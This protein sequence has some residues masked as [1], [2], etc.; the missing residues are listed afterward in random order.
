MLMLN[1]AMIICLGFL[2]IQY[3]LDKRT[4]LIILTMLALVLWTLYNE[5]AMMGLV[6]LCM[7]MP[8]LYLVQLPREYQ[9][10][11]L[12]YVTKWFAV[13]LIPSLIIYWI[14]LIF[15]IPSFGTFVHPNYE[16]FTNYLFFIKTTFDY[17]TFIRFN[18]FFLEPGHLAIVCVFLLMANKFDITHNRWLW[19]ILTAVAFSFS[20]AG[21]LLT[22]AGFAL[23]K[24]NSIARGISL[25]AVLLGFLFLVQNISGG[26]NAINE[27]IL[28]RLKYDEDKGIQGNNRFFNNTDFE[29][30]KALKNGDYWDGVSDKANMDLIGGAGYKIYILKHGL[31]GVFL[32]MAFYLAIIPSGY[33]RYYTLSFL[34]IIALCFMQ[35]AYPGWYSWLLPYVIGLDL[36]RKQNHEESESM[37]ET[38][39]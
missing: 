36:N 11:L 18:A 23:M 24:V 32:V 16:P 12:A 5:T 9:A 38:P 37:I 10:D 7:Y 13:L 34:F 14:T 20:L 30:D 27:L 6:M 35:N 2:P 8:V 19:V 22:F 4:G 1:I 26:N 33:N 17:G 28:E 31:I 21:Y 39:G 29:Y 3:K 15:T 25:L